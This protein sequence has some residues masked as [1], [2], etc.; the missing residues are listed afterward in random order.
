MLSDATYKFDSSFTKV[1]NP[2]P[3]DA[4]QTT[5]PVK[6]TDADKQDL[7]TQLSLQIN[8]DDNNTKIHNSQ[9]HDGEGADVKEPVR[10][11]KDRELAELFHNASTN[12]SID[13]FVKRKYVS[14]RTN[15]NLG[16]NSPDIILFKE[17]LRKNVLPPGTLDIQKSTD[18]E[19]NN[20]YDPS[21]STRQLAVM[22]STLMGKSVAFAGGASAELGVSGS[23]TSIP[24]DGPYHQP[25]HSSTQSI[26]SMDGGDIIGIENEQVISINLSN[27]GIGNER[28]ICLSAALSYCPHLCV[29]KL[30]NNR[31]SDRSLSMVLKAVFNISYCEELDVSCNAVGDLSTTCLAEY[32]QVSHCALRRLNV[33]RCAIDDDNCIALCRSLHHNESLESLDISENLAIQDV[34]RF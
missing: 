32:L 26:G 8:E 27:R 9:Y 13:T 1:F 34:R 2:K 31:L 10:M 20:S 23:Y 19:L 6:D 21:V 28:G 15:Q 4:L 33:R 16:V 18:L 7:L 12:N 25:P 11:P 5:K 24:E 30:S 29:I 14:M 17:C 22:T 3:L